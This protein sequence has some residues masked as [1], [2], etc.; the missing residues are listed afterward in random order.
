MFPLAGKVPTLSFLSTLSPKSVHR[1]ELKYHH[2]HQ[3]DHR[4]I[5]AL[6]PPLLSWIFYSFYWFYSFAVVSLFSIHP[7]IQQLSKVKYDCSS[8]SEIKSVVHIQHTILPLEIKAL[9]RRHFLYHISPLYYFFLFCSHFTCYC[10]YTLLTHIIYARI[11]TSVALWLKN[12]QFSLSFI[13]FYIPTLSLKCRR[14]PSGKKWVFCSS[15][16]KWK[17]QLQAFAIK[18]AVKIEKNW[19]HIRE[20]KKSF[21]FY[22]EKSQVKETKRVLETSY[23]VARGRK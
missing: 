11:T 15:Y 5:F 18:V 7:S 3:R 17:S 14:S 19:G 20:E 2:Q 6:F 13:Y 1:E 21:W 22:N 12:E 10:K 16:L 9:G 23:K 8:L 4:H